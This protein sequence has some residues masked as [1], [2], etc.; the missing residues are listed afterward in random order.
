MSS[1]LAATVRPG[2]LRLPTSSVVSGAQG[3]GLS[4]VYTAP[5][6]AV[7][8]AV[9]V[10]V[11]AGFSTPQ[12][13]S[14]SAEGFLS[15]SS[16]CA[17]FQIS[18]T[19]AQPDGSTVVTVATNCAAGQIGTISYADVTVPTAPGSYAFPGTFTPVGSVPIP[20][21]TTDTITVKAGVLATLTISP[22]TAT[23]PPGATQN[24]V[25]Q[26][27]DAVGNP[28]SN[29][30][31]YFTIAPDGSCAL[32][33]CTAAVPG[34]HTVTAKAK[35]LTATSALTVV[36]SSDADLSIAQTVS[37][38][39]PAYGSAVTFT[40]TVTNTSA[41]V[42]ST[43]VTATVPV[44]AGLASP[45]PDPSGSTS[46]NPSTGTWTVGSL[47]PGASATLALSGLAG[48]VSLGTQ[49]VTT[50]VTAATPDANSANNTASAS[51][52]PRPA[53][54]QVVITADPGN[55]PPNNVDIGV[56]GTVSWTATPVNADSPAAATPPGTISWICESASGNPCPAVPA[57]FPGSDIRVLTFDRG[58]FSSVDT[59][60]I[61]ALFV[62]DGATANYVP[63]QVFAA[64]SFTLTNNG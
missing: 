56:P 16:S 11:P 40:T 51:E 61:T 8:G 22:P 62:P 41:T 34:A 21:P 27:F 35:G 3:I 47:A 13:G 52:T 10:R 33:T 5:S 60:T 31:A 53:A 32:S 6:G 43:G 9:S 59:I 55:P 26:G 28:L 29:P 17:Q 25:V 48:D 37:T 44:P 14:A 15:T 36:G 63:E 46:Y 64:T 23:I 12:T 58:Q 4:L 7:P 50:S 24:Y 54:T 1:A 38:A 2:Q 39:T 49:T 20:F 18:G 19:A 45:A 57:L 30:G 42:T